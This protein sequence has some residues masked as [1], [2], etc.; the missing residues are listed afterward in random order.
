MALKGGSLVV[1]ATATVLSGAVPG[2]IRCR[3]LTFNSPTGNTGAITVGGADVDDDGNP[4]YFTIQPGGSYTPPS[5]ADHGPFEVD[6]T[7]LYCI[8]TAGTEVLQIVYID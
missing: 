2:K 1:G 7:K 3:A 4:G 6:F 5:P 8:S